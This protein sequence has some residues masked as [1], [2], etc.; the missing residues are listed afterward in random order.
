MKF[1]LQIL[2]LSLLG[3]AYGEEDVVGGHA[4]ERGQF[5]YQVSVQ[6]T[7]HFCG[8]SIISPNHVLTAAHCVV[9]KKATRLK[10]RAGSL[11]HASGGVIARVSDIV[12]HAGYNA[13]TIQNDI[14]ILKLA[15]SLPYGE[16]IG[17]ADLPSAL[18]GNPAPE[19]RCSVTGWGTTSQGS[20]YLPSSLQVAYVNTISL[21]QCQKQYE[22]K[23]FVINDAVVCAG[24]QAGGKDACQGD[25]GGPLVDTSS[26]KQIGVVSGGFGC[27]RHSYSGVYMSTAA[28]AAWIEEQLLLLA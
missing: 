13:E 23:Q 10:I 15:Q 3:S 2:A 28:Y 24:A 20:G 5:P 16:Q 25:S 19:T 17:A 12:T 7:S 11:R 27:A 9:D 14:A 21:E 22:G 1:S 8:G 6:T 4:A 26:G 18:D